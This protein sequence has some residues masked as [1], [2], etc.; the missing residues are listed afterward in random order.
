MPNSMHLQRRQSGYLLEV[1]LIL[2]V[3]G[4]ALALLLPNVS[5]LVGKILLCFAAPVVIACLY[6]MI[7][8]PGWQ[9]GPPSRLNRTG[10]LIVFGL[11]SILIVVG[12]GT[13]VIY[14]GS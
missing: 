7:V 2:S 8:I 6:Y 9:P 1:P 3:I 13:Y 12:T 10:K 5:V 14:G 4:I 11:V